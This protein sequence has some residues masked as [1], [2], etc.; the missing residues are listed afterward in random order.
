M[1]ALK[2]IVT[3]RCTNYIYLLYWKPVYMKPIFLGSLHTRVSSCVCVCT[4][5]ILY[6]R[7]NDNRVYGA[8]FFSMGICDDLY[9]NGREYNI[10]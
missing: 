3:T 8:G 7:L 2:K 9:G 5:V 10:M 4:L 1:T 6:I